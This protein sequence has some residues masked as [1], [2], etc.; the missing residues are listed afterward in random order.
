MTTKKT[1]N[2][3]EHTV[4]D[5]PTLRRQRRISREARVQK[6]VRD[7]GQGAFPAVSRGWEIVEQLIAGLERG[8]L[9]LDEIVD[10]MFYSAAAEVFRREDPA[11]AERYI[12]DMVDGTLRDLVRNGPHHHDEAY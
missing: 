11:S 2:D 12:R 6:L 3:N 5:S 1:T 9:T 8:G 4:T 7:L 10:A